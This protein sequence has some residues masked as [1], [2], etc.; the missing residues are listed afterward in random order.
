MEVEDHPVGLPATA[1]KAVVGE[2]HRIDRIVRSAVLTAVLRS[3]PELGPKPDLERL[4]LSLK[5]LRE[6]LPV[7]LDTDRASA[8]GSGYVHDAGGKIPG[9]NGR[10][11]DGLEVVEAGEHRQVVRRVGLTVEH[12]S[13]AVRRY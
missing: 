10:S 8:R 13:P 7:V 2:G 6:V 4:S 9:I 1:L 5:R 11:S 3:V 12:A